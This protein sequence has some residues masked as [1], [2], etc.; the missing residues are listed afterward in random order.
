[1]NSAKIIFA[2]M[3]MAFN[4]QKIGGIFVIKVFDLFNPITIKILYII[5]KYY[6][7]FN[8]YKPKTSR[9]A[10]S[11]KY[12]IARGFKGINKEE[13]EELQNCLYNWGDNKIHYDFDGVYITDDFYKIISEYN[14][15]F[16]N[17]QIRYIE[18][19]LFYINN[20]LCKEE[21]NNI[22]SNQVNNA[23]NW[24]RTHNLEINKKSRYYNRFNNRF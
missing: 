21:Y 22:I 13:L 24:V 6:D 10:N 5:Y 3:L 23:I 15:E 4:I 20:K 19:T 14:I 18:E 2:E 11:E 8:I 17:N 12:I 9:P 1:M 16:V 7:E